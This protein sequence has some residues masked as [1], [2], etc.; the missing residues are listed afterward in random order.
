[1]PQVAPIVGGQTHCAKVFGKK[2]GKL[3][4]EAVREIVPTD[5]LAASED[6]EVSPPAARD[7]AMVRPDGTRLDTG[8]E[9][10]VVE[11][12]P[13]QVDH[14]GS[15]IEAI[16]FD[17]PFWYEPIV[18]C[19]YV[20]ARPG[21][22]KGWG[23]HKLGHDRYFIPGGTT[24]IVLYDGRVRSSTFESFAQFQFTDEAPGLLRIPAGVWHASQ[25]WGDADSH[26]L[27]FNTRP[28]DH[29]NPDKYRLDPIDGPIQFDWSLRDG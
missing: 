25:N 7:R 6:L 1:V 13:R 27:V 10:V 28:Y 29:A 9:G 14:R 5:P 21:R 3:R 17:M 15:L 19:E 2:D 26:F 22:I 18:H 20:T 12:L 11:R 16:N 8:I 23:M 24:R 4:F